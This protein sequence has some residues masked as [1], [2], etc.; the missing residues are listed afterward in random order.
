MSVNMRYRNLPRLLLQ[1]REAWMYQARLR[2]RALG[3]SDQQWRVLRVLV[4]HGPSDT[5]FV[6]REA[7]I[8]GP[9]LTG[10]LV[11]M[12]RDD[13]I[14]RERDPNDHR[15]TLIQAT[16]QGQRAARLV[17][18]DAEAHYQAVQERMG[19][20]RLNAL[21]ELLDE[22]IAAHDNVNTNDVLNQSPDD[23]TEGAE[24]T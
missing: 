7:F 24:G 11:R 5:G 20:E 2:L 15:R 17:L 3:L 14:T 18:P 8:P 9:S 6:V 16:P 1:A 23:L 22:F 12:E 10:V 4:E 13:L 21:Y 19:P